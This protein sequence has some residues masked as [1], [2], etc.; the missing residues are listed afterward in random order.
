[1]K[2]KEK[3]VAFLR[4]INVGGHHKVPMAQLKEELQNLGLENTQTLLNSG[5]VIFEATRE[6]TSNLEKKITLH[7]EKAF[8]FSIPTLIRKASTIQKL[9]AMQPFREITR[10]KDIRCYVSLLRKTP[11]VI[12]EYPWESSDSSYKILE[13]KDNIIISVLNLSVS[14]SPKAMESLEKYFGKDITTR[15]WKTIER[16]G[17]KLI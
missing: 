6:S 3:Y 4:G 5:N 2:T 10:T 15:N 12:L 8:G 9:L 14:K 17:K 7:L 1:M 11:D 13:I 16:I